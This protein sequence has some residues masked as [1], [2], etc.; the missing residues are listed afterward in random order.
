MTGLW[1]P[2]SPQPV[3]LAMSHGSVRP[4]GLCAAYPMADHVSRSGLMSM[5]LI[6]G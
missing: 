6:A 1:N 3:K 4:M 2:T 5:G